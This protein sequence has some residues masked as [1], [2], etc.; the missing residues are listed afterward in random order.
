MNSARLDSQHLA[1]DTSLSSI[2]LLSPPSQL[3]SDQIFLITEGSTA[4]RHDFWEG[5]LQFIVGSAIFG[6]LLTTLSKSRSA[7]AHEPKPHE[8]NNEKA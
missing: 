6:L 4:R 3:N 5:L 8:N 1:S 7:L 2:S